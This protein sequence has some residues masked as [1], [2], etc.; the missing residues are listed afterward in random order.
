MFLINRNRKAY[1]PRLKATTIKKNL[2]RNKKKWREIPEWISRVIPVFWRDVP[3]EIS[4]SFRDSLHK[5][6]WKSF[7]IKYWKNIK[8]E[9]QRSSS[10]NC[11][12]KSWPIYWVNSCLL[13]NYLNDCWRVSVEILKKLPKKFLEKKSE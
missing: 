9:Y 11:W 2:N 5:N 1:E 4:K 3:Q 10:S 6:F 13:C 7:W 12:R 8:L